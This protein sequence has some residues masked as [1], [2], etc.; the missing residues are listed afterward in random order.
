MPAHTRTCMIYLKLRQDGEQIKR[1][2][3]KKVSTS[4]RRPLGRPGAANQGETSGYGYFML[5][6]THRPTFA[7]EAAQ[8]PEPV[9]AP[10]HV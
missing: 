6:I 3:R 5:L 8:P 10:V 1:R 7:A 4:E 9:H 2:Q